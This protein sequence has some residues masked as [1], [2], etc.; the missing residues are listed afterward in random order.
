MIGKELETA[1]AY[2]APTTVPKLEAAL[3]N[4]LL[5]VPLKV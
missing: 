3:L 5:A 4:A 2:L 1:R